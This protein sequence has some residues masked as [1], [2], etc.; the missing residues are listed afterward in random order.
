MVKGDEIK[1]WYLENNY[2]NI[3]GQLG[4]SC[5]RK[6]SCQRYFDIY[7]K[8]PNQVSLL[9]LKGEDESKIV[10]RALIWTSTENKIIM[11][12]IY[13]IKDSDYV[14]FKN[15]AIQN[16]WM[17]GTDFSYT[18]LLNIKIKLEN[19]MFDKYPYMD[20]FMCL[21]YEDGILSPNEDNWPKDGWWKLQET[22][23]EHTE[24]SVV[25]SDYHDQYISQD[26]AVLCEN[27]DWVYSDQAVYLE[28][29][30]ENSG[31]KI[32]KNMGSFEKKRDTKIQYKEETVRRQNTGQKFCFF[33]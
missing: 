28:Y 29:K 1:H 3:T 33:F 2:E 15:Y 19:W 4:N 10:G 21:N 31:K 24:D 12:R 20:T 27:G 26:E 25:W 30:D 32:Q 22:N 18:E 23:G 13:T 6:L 5:M 16:S 7:T 8:N 14:L 11:D 17:S 9:I